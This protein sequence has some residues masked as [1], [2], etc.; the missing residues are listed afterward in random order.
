MQKPC[1]ARFVFP[2][3]AAKFKRDTSSASDKAFPG[4]FGV[5]VCS[6]T[7]SKTRVFQY[8][9]I[10]SL[11][12]IWRRH[13]VESRTPTCPFKQS[14]LSIWSLLSWNST[15]T[16]FWVRLSIFPKLFALHRH[17]HAERSGSCQYKR[18]SSTVSVRFHTTASRRSQ[19]RISVFVPR[20]PCASGS[21]HGRT[22]SVETVAT[23]IV[24]GISH[25]IV[26]FCKWYWLAGVWC[27][28]YVTCDDVC[29]FL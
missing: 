9:R 7:P 29:C 8:T 5:F 22:K 17:S 19:V 16:H 23:R 24:T 20:G 11:L 2:V 27:Q 12:V 6:W 15:H 28:V 21:H 25:W 4:F 14:N 26:L 3:L 1:G 18:F 13:S 10:H